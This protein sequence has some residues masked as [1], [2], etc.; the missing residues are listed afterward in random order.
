MTSSSTDANAYRSAVFAEAWPEALGRNPFHIITAWNPPGVVRAVTEN[1]LADRRLRARLRTL[2][3]QAVRVTGCSPDMVHREPGWAAACTREHA[4]VLARDFGQAAVFSVSENLLVLV[5][6][7]G[8][9]DPLGPAM[10]RFDAG[11]DA[12]RM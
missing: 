8:K 9:E 2:G 11:R 4:L 3:A 10:P 12:G 6:A 7:G 5:W 1:R